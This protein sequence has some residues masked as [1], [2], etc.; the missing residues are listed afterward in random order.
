ML[1]TATELEYFQEIYRT[2]H[3]SKAAIRVGVSQPTL[4]QS[5]QKLEEKTGVTLFV[6]TKQ[7]LVSTKQGDHFFQKSTQLLS[8]WS[9]ILDSIKSVENEWVGHFRLGCHPSVGTYV[10][11]DFFKSTNKQLPKVEFELVHEI[12]RKVL[13]KVVS[14]E[15]D[16]AF[17]VNPFRHPDLVLKK[18]GTDQVTA[19]KGQGIHDDNAIV[20]ADMNLNQS[21]DVFRKLE[22]RTQ[23]KYRLRQCSNLELIRT[24]VVDGAGVGILPERVAKVGGNKILHYL[25]DGPSF[26][27]EIYLAYRKDFMQGTCAKEVIKIASHSLEAV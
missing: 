23:K 25:K 7:G 9:G 12:S 3:L 4:T 26:S 11:P 14:F 27:D 17:V 22:K 20:F 10:L 24:L 8:T 16:F 21:E 6:R 2:K 1:P 18:I 5:L 13:E 19:W 15:I